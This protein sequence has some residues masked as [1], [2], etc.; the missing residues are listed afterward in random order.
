MEKL[1]LQ[2]QE[3][4]LKAKDLEAQ[5]RAAAEAD[6]RRPEVRPHRRPPVTYGRPLRARAQCTLRHRL[7]RAR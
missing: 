7:F 2:L 3:A 4:E 6:A 5:Q 1:R